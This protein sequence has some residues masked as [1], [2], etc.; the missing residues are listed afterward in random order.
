M[1]GRAEQRGEAEINE[2]ET[3]E[4]G[5]DQYV[6]WPQRAVSELTGVKALQDIDQ[7]KQQV[8]ARSRGERARLHRVED[9]DPL[10]EVTQHGRPPRIVDRRR[11]RRR[12]G[13]LGG[14]P[15]SVLQR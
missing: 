14:E 1:V 8:G 15:K 6:S 9:R 11:K 12:D 10:P 5:I 4:S 2:K 13:W 3:V 7:P